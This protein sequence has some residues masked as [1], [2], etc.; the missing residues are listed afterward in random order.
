MDTAWAG[1]VFSSPT[2]L[3]TRSDRNCIYPAADGW[4]DIVIVIQ[5]TDPPNQQAPGPRRF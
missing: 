5:V 1:R 4:W 3:G 2:S